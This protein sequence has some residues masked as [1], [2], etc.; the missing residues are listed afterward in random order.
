MDDG[1]EAATIKNNVAP[2]L[3]SK[4]IYQLLKKIMKNKNR[5]LLALS[6]AFALALSIVVT[7]R[8]KDKDDNPKAMSATVSN[9]SFEP[10]VVAA[11]AM[12]NE[13]YLS[14]LRVTSSDS[15]MLQVNFP[16]TCKVN[17]QYNF[18]DIE[19]YYDNYTKQNYYGNWFSNAHGT[20][21]L[22]TFDKTNKKIAGTFSGVLFK[23]ANDKDSIVI[24][25]GQF[26]T[27]YK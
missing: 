18:D 1:P 19:I 2:F 23:W 11:Y 26:N 14:G 15:I 17:T 16:D 22:N 5:Q 4:N 9:S 6:T 10:S 3:L 27:T 24:N 25:N 21:K 8:K 12:S 20:F 7:S 13:I